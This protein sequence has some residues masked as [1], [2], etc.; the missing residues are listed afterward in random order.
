MPRHSF[1]LVIRNLEMARVALKAISG[2]TCQSLVQAKAIAL[3][4]IEAF[5]E[6]DL[7]TEIDINR[8]Y[9]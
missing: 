6:K 4:T 5:D 3:A 1:A 9:K 8:G 2:P 7:P